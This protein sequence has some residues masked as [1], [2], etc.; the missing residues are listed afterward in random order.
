MGS[1]PASTKT[2]EVD[3]FN[4]IDVCCG[5]HAIVTGG[6][7]FDVAVTA[8][9]EVLPHVQVVRDG[10]TVE[11][12]LDGNRGGSFLTTTLEVRNAMPE[13]QRVVLSGGARLEL[14][15]SIRR[16]LHLVLDGSGGARADL[17]KMQVDQA[18][19][20]L[21]GGSTAAVTTTGTLDYD[22]DGGSALDYFGHPHVGQGATS[23]GASASEE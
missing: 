9:Q 20:R 16:G 5:F 8:D 23:G 17:T 15:E 3:G 21:S 7:N 4:G 12:T 10:G 18:S 6:E 11:R 1:G 2:Y 13:L 19:A 22:L 14:G